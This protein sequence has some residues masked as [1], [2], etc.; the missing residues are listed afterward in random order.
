LP[1]G[2][3]VI[4][5]D[6]K[7]QRSIITLKIEPHNVE[8]VEDS[9]KPGSIKLHFTDSFGRRHRLCPASSRKQRPS[10]LK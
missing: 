2:E 4:P 7:V 5:S 3:K 1:P 9:Y 8:I 6:H 10:R